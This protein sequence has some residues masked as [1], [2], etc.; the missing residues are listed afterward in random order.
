MIRVFTRTWWKRNPA[1]PG[2]RE[3]HAGRKTTIARVT[4]EEEARAICARWNAAH[5]PGL[6]GR[7]AEYTAE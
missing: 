2:G 3:P 6:T 4:T 5:P 1:T 7:K